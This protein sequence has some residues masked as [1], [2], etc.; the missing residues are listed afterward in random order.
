MLVIE[1]KRLFKSAF[2]ISI[3]LVFQFLSDPS[4]AIMAGGPPDSPAARVDANTTTST[5]S[6]VGSVKVNGVGYSGVAIGR[7]HVLT[8]GHVVKGAAPANVSYVLNYGANSSH[9]IPAAAIFPHPN[10]ISFNS[11]NLNNDIAIV[12]LAEPIPEGVPI[13]ELNTVALATGTTLTLVGYGASGNGSIGVT[14]GAVE[15][16]KR[17]G[18]N[19]ADAFILDDNGSGKNE[20]FYFDFDGG[21]VT[22]QLGGTSLGNSIEST[23]ASNDS[24]SP[25]FIQRNG[26]WLVA[27]INTFIF[28]F[29]NGPMTAGT[30]GTG[31]GGQLVDAYIDW[32]RTIVPVATSTDIPTLPEWAA[33]T[34]ATILLAL[35]VSRQGVSKKALIM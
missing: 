19:Q 32:I 8:A 5:W 25:S 21:G 24:G 4:Y 33:I 10:F 16:V 28:T 29:P 11:P 9:N 14:V 17:V 20:I 27:G 23:L 34:L 26:R 30:F 2:L 7:Y 15:T 6:G 35:V 13:Y 3:V 1:M 31:G 12:E 18:S 22:N